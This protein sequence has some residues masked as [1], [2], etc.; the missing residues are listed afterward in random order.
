MIQSF[1]ETANHNLKTVCNYLTAIFSKFS[2]LVSLML[3]AST[4]MCISKPYYFRC[5][6]GEEKDVAHLKYYLRRKRSRFIYADL[7]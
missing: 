2:S 7:V 4:R 3:D 1:S 6:P 5:L